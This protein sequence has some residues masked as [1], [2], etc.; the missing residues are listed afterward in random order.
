MRF[1]FGEKERHKTN[2]S[3]DCKD[4]EVNLHARDGH[5]FKFNLFESIS[6]I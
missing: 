3:Y 4:I 6:S 1:P 5:I 2:E